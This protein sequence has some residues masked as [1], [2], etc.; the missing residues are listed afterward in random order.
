MTSEGDVALPAIDRSSCI[1]RDTAARHGRTKSVEPGRTAAQKLHYGRIVLGGGEPIAFET[2]GLETGLICV[3][4]NAR[5]TAG[6]RAFTMQP[7]D[8]LYVPR[9][10]GVRVEPGA[11][12]CDLVEIA[13]PIEGRYPLQYVSYE[14]V[15]RDPGLHFT[16]GG[17]GSRRTLNILLGKNVEAG[18]IMAGITFSEPGNW[19]SWPPHEHAQLAE[20]A[21][22]YLDMPHPA[23]GVQLVYNSSRE[24]E[25]A[26]IMR[27]GDVVLMPQGYH[28]N[29]A[30][31][32]H[33]INFIWMM[34][35]N[36]ERED[37]LFG[38]VHVHPDF[39]TS[40]SGLDAGKK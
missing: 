27:D 17:D 6:D 24:P 12:G 32:G 18:R 22:L 38:V 28:P 35:A 7:Y 16:A 20:E 25:L 40:V 31:P 14:D 39:A 4:G 11:S 37:R 2:G 26:T 33:S 19:T 13:A 5:V 8:A 36:R 34:A 1:V 30:A 3:K 21:Y 10:S 23:F 9:D 29:V 15:Q